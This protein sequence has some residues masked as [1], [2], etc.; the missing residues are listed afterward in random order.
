MTLAYVIILLASLLLAPFASVRFANQIYIE[1]AVPFLSTVKLLGYS[2][3]QKSKVAKKF[4]I[5]LAQFCD[6]YWCASFVSSLFVIIFMAIAPLRIIIIL[7]GMSEITIL[8]NQ[9]LHRE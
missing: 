7:Y 4:L 9:H 8:V 1:R 2:K 6:C 5:W 3:T